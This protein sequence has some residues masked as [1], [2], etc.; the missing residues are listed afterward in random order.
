MT[1]ASDWG[2]NQCRSKTV[3]GIVETK[4]TRFLAGENRSASLQTTARFGVYGVR[5]CGFSKYVAQA[6]WCESM[7]LDGMARLMNWL[8]CLDGSVSGLKT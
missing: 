5:Q 3:I 2:P 6:G 7:L 1:Q 8:N 4:K